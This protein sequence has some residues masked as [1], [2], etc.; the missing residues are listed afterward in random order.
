M[1]GRIICSLLI[2]SMKNGK[3]AK[4][5][6]FF[7]RSKSYERTYG[8]SWFLKLHQELKASTFD[9]SHGWSRI[10]QPLADLLVQKYL[11]FLPN[12]IYPI[13]AGTHSNTAF[14]LIFPLYYAQ[15]DYL[16]LPYSVGYLTT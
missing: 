13:R 9:E 3:V 11:D 8:W 12:L 7:K 16:R 6:D 10:L 15:G 2:Y 1:A 4:E 14:G 5:V